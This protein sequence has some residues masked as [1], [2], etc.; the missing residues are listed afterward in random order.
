M[1]GV[2]QWATVSENAPSARK[3]MVLN[4]DEIRG[5]S[6]IRYCIWFI[7]GMCVGTFKIFKI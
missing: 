4:I 2:N 6:A 3:E 1:D 5:Y 7:Y